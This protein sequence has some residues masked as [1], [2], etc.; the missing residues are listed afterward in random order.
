[1]KVIDLTG[2]KFER[3]TVI[4]RSYPN[5]D[6]GKAMWLCK[7]EC[8][9]EKIICGCNLR[10]GRIKSCGCLLREN[11]GKKISPGLASIRQVISCYK[12]N[13][14]R[15]GFEYN[16]TEEQFKEITQQDCYYCGE[17]PNNIQKAYHNNGDYTYNGIDRIDNNKGYTIDNVVSCC[18]TC[19]RAKDKHTVKEFYGWIEKVYIRKKSRPFKN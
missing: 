1:M 11:R 4:K 18:F 5:K 15:R 10:N 2:Q 8:G 17:K 13:A 12:R 3:L 7:C 16:L 19:N 14:K 9:I 6:Y